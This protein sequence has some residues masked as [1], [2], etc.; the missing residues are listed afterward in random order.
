MM[1]FR[2]SMIWL[3]L[4]ASLVSLSSL[5]FAAAEK[6][7]LTSE[8][9]VWNVVKKADGT[10]TLQPA[11]S[12]KPGDVLQY[13]A[14]YK[15]ADSRAVSRLVASLPIPAGTEL[16]AASALPREVQASLDGK[17]YAATP[18]MRKLRRADGQMA[19]V[20]VPLTEYRYLRWP[21]QQVAAGATFSTSARVRVVSSLASTSTSASVPP[22]ASATAV[23][24][25]PTP[26]TAPAA[27]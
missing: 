11:Q 6:A 15:N 2:V 18:L 20:P 16:V 8:L 22:S 4:A 23:A 24:P 13:T 14:V 25:T 7:T 27:R 1:S 3:P 12:V 21:E 9:Q 5:T 19:D 10:E 17:V 26:A